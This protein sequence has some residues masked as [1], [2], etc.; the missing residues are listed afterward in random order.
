MDDLG[1]PMWQR[2][3]NHLLYAERILR[4]LGDNVSPHPLPPMPSKGR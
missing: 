2:A 4:D 1:D 3:S